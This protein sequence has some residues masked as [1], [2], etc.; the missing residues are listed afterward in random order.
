M[1]PKFVYKCHFCGKEFEEGKEAS[2]GIPYY[3]DKNGNEVMRSVCFECMDKLH[4]VL[5]QNE[6]SLSE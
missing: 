5:K 4:F 3:Y 6:W 1:Y 2:F